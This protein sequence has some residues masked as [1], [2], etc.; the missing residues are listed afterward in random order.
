MG[1][2]NKNNKTNS[3][4]SHH[5]LSWPPIYVQTTK[6]WTCNE[7]LKVP[8]FVSFRHIISIGLLLM[9]HTKMGRSSVAILSSSFYLLEEWNKLGLLSQKFVS[10]IV[11]I[12]MIAGCFK[13]ILAS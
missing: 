9:F 2:I 11:G 12:Y 5:L 13:N 1:P 3:Q 4:Y 10:I 8:Y 7:C 6:R